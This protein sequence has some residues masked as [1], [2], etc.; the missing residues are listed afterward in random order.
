MSHTQN[1]WRVDRRITLTV[2]LAIAM[3]AGGALIWATG[4]DA[5]VAVIEH[6]NISNLNE[7]FIRLEERLDNVKRDTET[8][9]R[10]LDVI[11]ER[12]MRK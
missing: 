4:L 9:S 8:I 3:Q 2:L 5:R 10:R 7:R 1:H 6:T 11:D 12:L